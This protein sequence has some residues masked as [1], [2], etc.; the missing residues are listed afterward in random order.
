MKDPGNPKL[1]NTVTD[2]FGVGSPGEFA[3]TPTNTRLSRATANSKPG[4]SG[5]TSNAPIPATDLADVNEMSSP[6]GGEVH[7]S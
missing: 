3:H 7:R 1:G 6:R 4:E 2:Q 5:V